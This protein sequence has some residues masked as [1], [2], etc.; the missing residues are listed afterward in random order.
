M[1]EKLK[2]FLSDSDIADKVEV[3][4]IDVFEDNLD[5]HENIKMFMNRGLSLPLVSIGNVKF[6]YGGISDQ[7]IYEVAKE[8][9]K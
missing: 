4:F 3:N 2:V 1:V 9:L 7:Q 6:L 8:I 5:G